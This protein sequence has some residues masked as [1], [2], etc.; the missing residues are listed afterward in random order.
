MYVSVICVYFL[1]HLFGVPPPNDKKVFDDAAGAISIA[2]TYIRTYIHTYAINT[3][4]SELRVVS[5]AMWVEFF[6][7][8]KQR[9]FER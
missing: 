2:H 4:L 9:Y 8:G 7:G 5:R 6:A 1:R 3:F